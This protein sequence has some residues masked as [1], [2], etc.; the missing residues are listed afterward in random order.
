MIINRENVLQHLGM[1]LDV[2][3]NFV[4]H[5]NAKIEKANKGIVFII[6][7]HLSLPRASLLRIYKSYLFDP[8]W[9]TGITFMINPIT[10]QFQIR[11]N[12]FNL[13]LR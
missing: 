11:S 5:T 4:E 2:R 10:L 3:L 9:I 1:L 6:K 7:L 13:M 12:L 8:I